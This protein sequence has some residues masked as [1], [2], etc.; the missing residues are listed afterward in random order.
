MKEAIASGDF[1]QMATVSSER[2]KDDA[3]KVILDAK[4]AFK[5]EAGISYD[6]FIEGNIT[7][8]DFAKT[9]YNR[10]AGEVEAR[11]VQLSLIHILAER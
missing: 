11:N 2:L 9:R 6:K 10:L 4:K 7:I 3:F 5:E 8:E 1:V